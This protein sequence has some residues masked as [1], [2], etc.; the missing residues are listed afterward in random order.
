MAY[1]KKDNYPSLKKPGIY[2]SGSTKELGLDNDNLE[3]FSLGNWNSIVKDNKILVANASLLELDDRG[4][5]VQLQFD[6]DTFLVYGNNSPDQALRKEKYLL[7]CFLIRK[8]TD[9]DTGEEKI[10]EVAWR[11][12]NTH[13]VDGIGRKPAR[14][15]KLGPDNI[16]ISKVGAT[17][18]NNSLPLDI[19]TT[20]FSEEEQRNFVGQYAFIPLQDGNNDFQKRKR[21]MQVDVLNFYCLNT[22]DES[23]DNFLEENNIEPDGMVQA[24]DDGIYYYKFY[25]LKPDK[26]I[27]F[28]D[29]FGY[30]K[31]KEVVIEGEYHGALTDAITNTP[32][33]IELDDI[34]NGKFKNLTYERPFGQNN[35]EGVGD[36]ETGWGLSNNWNGDDGNWTHQIWFPRVFAYKT[37]SDTEGNPSTSRGLFN[38]QSYNSSGGNTYYPTSIPYDGVFESG[39]SIYGASNTHPDQTSNIFESS[40]F[41]GIDT[42]DFPA[43][44]W[45]PIPFATENILSMEYLTQQLQNNRT[46][47]SDTQKQWFKLGAPFFKADDELILGQWNNTEASKGYETQDF[48]VDCVGSSSENAPLYYDNESNEY[49]YTSYPLKVSLKVLLEKDQSFNNELDPTSYNFNIVDLLYLGGSETDDSEGGAGTRFQD[50]DFYGEQISGSVNYAS[51]HYRYKVIQWGDEKTL[52]TDDQIE[53]TY[54]FNIYNQEGYPNKNDYSFKKLS[55]DQFYD[56]KPIEEIN[57]H[58]YN[59]PGVKSI[60]IIISRITKDGALILQTYL[61]NKNIVINDGLLL[62]QDFSVFGGTD[63]NFLPLKTKDIEEE[64]RPLEAIIGG[65]DENSKYNNSVEKIKKDDNFIQDDYLE[66]VSSREFIN[67]FNKKLYGETPGQL[68]LSTTRMYKKPL[69]IYDFI[70]ADKLEWITSG[71]GTLPINSSATDIFISNNDCI[72]DLNPQDIEYLSIQNKTGTADKAILIGDYKVNQPK[73]GRVQRQGVMQTPLLEQNTDKQ[74]F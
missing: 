50:T 30:I 72:V 54:F 16:R 43:S 68:D 38:L 20:N 8:V 63:F 42:E 64:E 45:N 39:N 1:S 44:V 24:L 53:S 58:V 46:P 57:T 71:S 59:T 60:K 69:D 19:D 22:D 40:S 5:P 70:N 12:E 41:L 29:G 4:R 48:I 32:L 47:G 34:L 28:E 10:I 26:K 67:N 66:R 18:G 6:D 25:G 14:T 55:I 37:E 62:S 27:L 11:G 9:P 17:E 61:V 35:S 73:N 23:L 74:A 65:L 15:F 49:V 13:E 51:H 7:F 21:N 36:G 52:L 3:K 33:E 2:P 56:F 31:E